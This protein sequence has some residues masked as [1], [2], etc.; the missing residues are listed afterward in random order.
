MRKERSSFLIIQSIVLWQHQTMDTGDVAELLR[1]IGETTAGLDEVQSKLVRFMEKVKEGEFETKNGLSYLE[2]KHLLL[3]F[4]CQCIVFYILLK[5]NGR[6]VENHP[7]IARLIEIRLFLEKIRPID[8]KMR[9]QIEKLLKL[10]NGISSGAA[11]ED[12]AAVPDDLLYRPNPDMLVA[13]VDEGSL[14]EEAIYRPPMI[15]PAAMEEEK[16]LKNRKS[17]SRA[18]RDALQKASRSTLLK[19]LA[20]DL[21]GRPEE[22]K[23]FVGP[24]SK[25]MTR[26]LSRLQARAQAEENMFARVP[27]SRVEKKRVKHL[28]QSRNGLLGM[29]DDFD[30]DVSYLVDKEENKRSKTSS[31]RLDAPVSQVDARSWN[32]KKTTNRKRKKV[33]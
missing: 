13:K 24:E 22:I 18:Q 6:S 21:E 27:L 11:D 32:P 25:E 23:E 14:G 26:E 28:K 16:I 2:S 7:V 20:N 9:Y 1:V 29:L 10:A 3:L 15:A 30:D 5:A 4:Y 12:S 19:D 17:E 8:K 33:A 31:Q